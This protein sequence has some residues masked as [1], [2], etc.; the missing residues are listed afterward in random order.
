M[1]WIELS[2][3]YQKPEYILKR[4]MSHIH[5]CKLVAENQLNPRGLDRFDLH[6]AMICLAISRG[7]GNKKAELKDFIL[8]FDNEKKKQTPEEIMSGFKKLSGIIKANNR[9][10]GN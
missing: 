3:R 4:E 2:Y 10:A 1:F 9:R 6:T 5:F 8:D 7:F